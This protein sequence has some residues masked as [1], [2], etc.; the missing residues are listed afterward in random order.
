MLITTQG[1]LILRKAEGEGAGQGPLRSRS[2]VRVLIGTLILTISIYIYYLNVPVD[3]MEEDLLLTKHRLKFLRSRMWHVRVRAHVRVR[4]STCRFISFINFHQ[5]FI[6]FLEALLLIQQRRSVPAQAY[7]MWYVCLRAHVRVRV[8]T[9]LCFIQFFFCIFFGGSAVDSA[10]SKVRAC[11][12]MACVCSQA[13][14]SQS[15]HVP[16]GALCLGSC[17]VL[18]SKLA[19]ET[20]HTPRSWCARSSKALCRC[21]CSACCCALRASI[22]QQQCCSALRASFQMQQQCCC[23]LLRAS[24]HI[25][26]KC[27]HARAHARTQAHLLARA[28]AHIRTLKHMRVGGEESLWTFGGCRGIERRLLTKSTN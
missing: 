14:Q 8:S 26:S 7:Y 24:F 28:H 18:D 5:F 13:R 10:P 1:T 12:Y 15:H 23:C 11:A 25:Q 2:C 3:G 27:P 16:Q 9:C 22:Q 17:S 20:K 4:V 21:C 19:S 6:F